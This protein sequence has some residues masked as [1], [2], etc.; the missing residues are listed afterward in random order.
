MKMK[1][2]IGFCCLLHL[3]SFAG[4]QLKDQNRLVIP[5]QLVNNLIILP[6][7]LNG[8]S[9][10]FILDTGAEHTLL[11]STDDQTL[12]LNQVRK[13]LFNGLGGSILVEGLASTNNHLSI[14][15]EYID[16][17]HTIY[18]I[19]NEEFNFS[20]HLGVSI[21]G[22]IGY[23]FFKN[24][25][26]EIDYV[27]SKLYIYRDIHLVKNLETRFN[28]LPFSLE[29]NKPY[30]D[31]EI[32]VNNTY[33]PTKMLIDLGNADAVW[34]FPN[35]V[36]GFQFQSAE[37]EDY[38]GRGFNG[39]IRG[40]RGRIHSFKIG[41]DIFYKPIAA[42]PD[43]NYIAY[44]ARVNE[45]VGSI[46]A[47]ILSRYRLILDY[48]GKTFYYRKNRYFNYPFR[49]NMSGI[50][51]RHDGMKWSE[52]L[53]KLEIETP[54]NG[55]E[56][57]GDLGT[58]VYNAPTRFQYQLQLKPS[59][60]IA[61]IRKGSPGELAGLQKGDVLIAIK[62]IQVSRLSL[63]NIYHILSSKEDR[64]IKIVVERNGEQLIKTIQLKDPFPF[65]EK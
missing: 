8:V 6:V 37:I 21:N 7:N 23:D 24:Y 3:H 62:G 4:F 34:I 56:F 48:P 54:Y 29:Q 22:I 32:F 46:G 9:L 40:H 30:T 33:V 65:R 2:L 38:L 16:T 27:A 15:S 26:V 45:R 63:E 20:T 18:I 50:E 58:N 60:S 14:G 5:F 41:D 39:D 57:H 55:N 44:I 28:S 49:Y 13:M 36:P 25:P 59:Y 64:H 43:K 47:E 1:W 10:S 42:M 51:V 19:L 11:F 52:S 61:G 17:N 53:V 31:A 35:V 12:N